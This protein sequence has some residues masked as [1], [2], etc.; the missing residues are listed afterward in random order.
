MPEDPKVQKEQSG[1]ADFPHLPI[2]SVLN[3]KDFPLCD[4]YA[5]ATV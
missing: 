4:V 5:H 1:H 2:Y 3:V